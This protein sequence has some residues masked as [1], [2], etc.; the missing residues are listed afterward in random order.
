MAAPRR[1]GYHRA[2]VA[3][4]TPAREDLT[5]LQNAIDPARLA[6][7]GLRLRGVR[8]RLAAEA[9]DTRGGAALDRLNAVIDAVQPGD[10]PAADAPELDRLHVELGAIQEILDAAGFPGHAR[11]VSSVRSGLSDLVPSSGTDDEPPPP[12][13]FRP[14]PRSSQARPTEAAELPTSQSSVGRRPQLL[15]VAAWVVGLIAVVAFGVVRTW[16]RSES[17]LPETAATR[18]TSTPDRRS[19]DAAP[20][21]T[22]APWVP[23]PEEQLAAY[24]RHL[25]VVAREL[26]L[27]RTAL[28]ADDP[29][30]AV[31]HFAVAAA[32]D[33]HH[34]R[35]VDMADPL[36]DKLLTAADVAM[37]DGNWP[38]AEARIDAA[39]EIV[40]RFYLDA[41]P[42]QAAARRLATTSRFR[43]LGAGD[44]EAI[45]AAVG[46]EVRV[47]LASGDT[48]AG[49]MTAFDGRTV[50]LAVHSDVAGGR[51]QFARDVP[52]DRVHQVRVFGVEPQTP[53]IDVTPLR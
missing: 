11:V 41:E 31:R 12:R 14:P 26:D 10:H 7:V 42:V 30:T 38:E 25:A 51:V 36:V 35:V 1:L 2:K 40:E 6:Q 21:P 13:R 45:R 49:R 20:I 16:S 3:D 37:A 4:V 22:L 24:E 34:R 19:D 9:T 29:D 27:A 33:R 15:M 39:R 46:R 23:D 32:T 17:T 5:R 53:E 47:T 50:S 43:D 18:V 52:L 48:L 44:A 8:D 28:D